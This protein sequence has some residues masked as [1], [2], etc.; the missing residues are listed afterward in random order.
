MLNHLAIMVPTVRHATP[1]AIGMLPILI[2]G[3]H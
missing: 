2:P 1:P 3:S